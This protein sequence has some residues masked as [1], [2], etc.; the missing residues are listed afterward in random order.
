MGLQVEA[1]QV[2]VCLGRERDTMP[3]YESALILPKW[4]VWKVGILLG[5]TT[6]AVS[7]TT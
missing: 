6:T 5:V 4:V 3:I 2:S 7:Y 1:A